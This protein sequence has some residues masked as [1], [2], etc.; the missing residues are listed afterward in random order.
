V[1]EHVKIGKNDLRTT[2]GIKT[3]LVEMPKK[4]ILLTG[5]IMT[6]GTV[7]NYN[8]FAESECSFRINEKEFEILYYK[9]GNSARLYG[10]IGLAAPSNTSLFLNIDAADLSDLLLFLN[11]EEKEAFLGRINGK[12]SIEGPIRDLKTKGHLES[13]QG[14]IGDL[15]FETANIN[16]EG[17]GPYIKFSDSRM[18]QEKV[19]LVLEGEL[20]LRKIGK[21]RFLEEVKIKTSDG[22]V[23]WEGW[24]FS[25]GRGMKG[26]TF[27]SSNNFGFGTYAGEDIVRPGSAK[28]GVELEY[29]IRSKESL[30]MRMEE[31]AQFFGLE[32]KVKF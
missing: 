13:G 17:K 19:T 30:K 12:V 31:G 3:R 15:F 2:I 1:A 25:K 10:T 21:P 24:D 16:F 22:L 14:R 4:G 23:V 18:A 26:V 8:P 27:K 28:D 5:E 29:K 7:L 20:D 6:S 32:H 11:Q 9:F